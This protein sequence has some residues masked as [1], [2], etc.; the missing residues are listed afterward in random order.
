MT[1]LET[2]R[3]LIREVIVSDADDFLRYWQQDDYRRHVPIEP[4]TADF[5]AAKVNGWIQSQNQNPR[6]VYHLVVT[7]KRSN[8]MVGDAGLYIRSIS[9][10]Q[11]EIGWGVISSH[12]GQGLAT[13]IGRALLGL[14]FDT[15]SL[16]RVFAQCSV[17]NLASR[18][19]MTKLGIHE[20]AVLRE[21]VFARGEWWSSVQSSILSTEWGNATK[22]ES[23]RSRYAAPSPILAL[24]RC[25]Y[26]SGAPLPRTRKLFTKLSSARCGRRTRAI[27]P[28]RSSTD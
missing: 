27:T 1:E 15:L 7:H 22:A 11:G 19:I 26:R 14:A 6:T 3:L 18:R 2:D 8:Q 17:E 28:P 23:H 20:E 24:R 13:E 5:I 16:H 4:P 25:K 9:S 21:N 12:T 10:R